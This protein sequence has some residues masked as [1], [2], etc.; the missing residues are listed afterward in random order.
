MAPWS[1]GWDPSPVRVLVGLSYLGFGLW[2]DCSSCFFLGGFGW[3]LIPQ[4]PVFWENHNRCLLNPAWAWTLCEYVI[5]WCW[6]IPAKDLFQVPVTDLYIFIEIY[7]EIGPVMHVLRTG[8]SQNP[9]ASPVDLVGWFHVAPERICGLTALERAMLSLPRSRAFHYWWG[10]GLLWFLFPP[11]M[12]RTFKTVCT[13]DMILHFQS[14]QSILWILCVCGLIIIVT[15]IIPFSP[16]CLQGKI[17][18]FLS[19]FWRQK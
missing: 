12:Y 9:S 3:C 14:H 13:F 15:T 2:L 18:I 11:D 19:F 1:L 10:W 5:L 7:S 16:F 6:V 4:L 17:S 8:C